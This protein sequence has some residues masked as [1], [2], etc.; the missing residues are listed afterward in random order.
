MIIHLLDRIK[1]PL[2]FI[3]FF[4]SATTN[5]FFFLFFSFLLR[6]V[7]APSPFLPPLR[8]WISRLTGRLVSRGPTENYS[9]RR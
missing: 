7:R 2:V 9:F 4:K 3:F 8:L 1:Y 6:L 5:R